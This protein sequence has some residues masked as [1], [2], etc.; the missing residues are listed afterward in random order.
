MIAYFSLNVIE[1]VYLGRFFLFFHFFSW[2]IQRLNLV[3]DGLLFDY[4]KPMQTSR[5]EIVDEATS[6]DD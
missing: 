5:F 2:L 6:N 4:S 3:L 1:R